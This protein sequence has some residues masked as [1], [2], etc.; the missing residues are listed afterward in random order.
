MNLYKIIFLAKKNIIPKYKGKF[1]E[2]INVERKK[3]K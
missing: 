2:T 3:Q 1:V